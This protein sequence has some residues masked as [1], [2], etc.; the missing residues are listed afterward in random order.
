MLLAGLAGSFI[1]L[2]GF[3]LSIP[4]ALAVILV[5]ARRTSPLKAALVGALLTFAVIVGVVF[6]A[7]VI[8]ALLGNFD[9][10]EYCDGLC[11]SNGDGFTIA[12]FILLF[13]AVPTSIAGGVISLIASAVTRRPASSA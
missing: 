13:V 12:T 8:N 11:I 9:S 10:G 7:I 6:P 4:I 2:F 1:G 3:W 5:V